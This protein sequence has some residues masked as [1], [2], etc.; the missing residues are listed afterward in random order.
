MSGKSPPIFFQYILLLRACAALSVCVFHFTCGNPDFLPKTHWLKVIGSFGRYGVDV[1]F[2]ISGFVIPYSLWH[3]N[4][5]L[6]DL[7]TFLRRRFWRIELPY[8]ASLLLALAVGFIVA[9]YKQEVFQPS[10]AQV[11]AHFLY[12]NSILGYDWLVPVYWTLAIEFQFYIGIGLLFTGL[13]HNKIAI[14]LAF[15]LVWAMLAYTFP[16]DVG[17]F[18]YIG[19]FGLGILLCQF[20][21][22]RV[23]KLELACGAII[24]TGLNIYF[25]GY[26][27]TGAGLVGFAVI[28]WEIK[29]LPKKRVIPT[30]WSWVG[31]F[32]YSLYLVHVIIAGKIIGFVEQK[33]TVL[34]LRLLAVLLAIGVAIGVGYIFYKII[35]Q[36]TQQ[37]V[38]KN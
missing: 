29:A 14:R 36:P 6:Y 32:S 10:W 9:K 21:V 5:Q 8:L 15:W 2:V 23:G 31:K 4:Y 38:P 3:K 26:F 34:E 12:L 20:Q 22:G 13:F 37:R 30:F 16:T 19:L 18:S 27:S 1:F 25:V 17:F 7:P 33:T 11:G 28:L 24:A 35:E